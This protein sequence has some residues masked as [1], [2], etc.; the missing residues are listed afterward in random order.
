MI[1]PTL[2]AS[3]LLLLAF[4]AYLVRAQIARNAPLPEPDTDWW[5]TFE[6]QFRAHAKWVAQGRTM[7]RRDPTR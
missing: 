2:V 3:L 6:R 4:F 7:H 5:P 1:I